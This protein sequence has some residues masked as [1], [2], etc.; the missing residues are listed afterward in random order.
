MEII[1]NS[2]GLYSNSEG[3]DEAKTCWE[4]YEM[5]YKTQEDMMMMMMMIPYIPHH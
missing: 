3:T 2:S 5:P 4:R 1:N